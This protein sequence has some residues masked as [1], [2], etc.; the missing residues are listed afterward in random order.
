MAKNMGSKVLADMFKG[1][2]ITHVFYMPQVIS[3]ALVAMEE[4]G[5]RRVVA[6]SEKGAAYMAD[7]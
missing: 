1:Y 4:L 6:H 5:I 2:G 7:G 3:T